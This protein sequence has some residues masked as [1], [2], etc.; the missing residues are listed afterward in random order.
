MLLSV[1]MVEERPSRGV[2]RGIF[3]RSISGVKANGE[4]SKKD[5][6]YDE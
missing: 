3:C 5:K 6:T 4:G 1:L 2:A